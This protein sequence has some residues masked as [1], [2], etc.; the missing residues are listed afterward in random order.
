MRSSTFE[1]LALGLVFAVVL[2]ATHASGC[3]DLTP[4]EAAQTVAVHVENDTDRAVELYEI[5]A[6][7]HERL[8]ER[9]HAGG[10]AAFV[11]QPSGR[12][13]VRQDGEVLRRFTATEAS[14][15]SL[16]LVPKVLAA[17]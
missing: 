4:E 16:E 17:H 1:T 14:W 8:V 10:L 12:W 15:Q 11:T 7:G 13:V 9:I 5:D 6:A 2:A 3:E